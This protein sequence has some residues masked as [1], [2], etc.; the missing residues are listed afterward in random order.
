M[1]IKFLENNCLDTVGYWSSANS[2]RSTTNRWNWFSLARC[3]Q[4]QSV[5]STQLNSS[6]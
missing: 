5:N 1:F 6:L 4:R 2:F 3:H